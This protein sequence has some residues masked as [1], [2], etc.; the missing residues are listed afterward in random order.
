MKH[1]LALVVSKCNVIERHASFN[2]GHRHGIG[3]T[4]RFRGRIDNLK[5]ALSTGH[6]TRHPG[7]DHPKPFQRTVEQH[8]IAV[9]SHQS[10]ERQLPIDHLQPPVI[11][12]NNHAS[13]RQQGHRFVKNAPVDLCGN[14][15][16]RQFI[17]APFEHPNF[18]LF[19]CK[20][21]HHANARERFIDPRHSVR[22]RLHPTGKKFSHSPIKRISPDHD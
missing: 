22:P 20:C 9:K 16:A 12:H 10:A 2:I 4:I 6:C 1:G 17:I 21:L 11:P 3:I 14:A 18:L 7:I 8:H 15:D 13:R 19:L 5:N